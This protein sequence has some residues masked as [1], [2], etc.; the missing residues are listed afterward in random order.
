MDHIY[1]NDELTCDNLPMYT[2]ASLHLIPILQ[3]DADLY[4]KRLILLEAL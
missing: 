2:R 3:A 1:T 4:L